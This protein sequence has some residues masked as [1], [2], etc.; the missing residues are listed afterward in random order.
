MKER[1][2]LSCS[3]VKPIT[4]CSQPLMKSMS[5][6]PG[7]HSI[8]SHFI[9]L[10]NK[11]IPLCSL[12]DLFISFMNVDWWIA[13]WGRPAITFF[14]FLLNC[15]TNPPK[16]K[17]FIGCRRPGHQPINQTIPFVQ[18]FTNSINWFIWLA[19]LFSA[20]SE[21]I[22]KSQSFQDFQ[23]VHSFIP[24]GPQC[25]QQIKSKSIFPLGREDWIWFVL[26]LGSRKE[27]KQLKNFFNWFICLHSSP[28]FIN[29]WSTFTVWFL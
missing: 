4:N 24:L 29:Y 18:F 11:S 14:F 19:P 23:F 25:A 12:I 26:L 27:I 15:P 8:N 22:H 17:N 5:E 3:G 7:N 28:N 20:G 16:K 13:C 10:T 2:D 1:V 9:S 21:T 6:E